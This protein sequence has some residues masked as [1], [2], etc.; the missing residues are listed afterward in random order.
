VSCR[1]EQI[2]LHY[3]PVDAALQQTVLDLG[4]LPD[5]FAV[6]LITFVVPTKH[7][8]FCVVFMINSIHKLTLYIPLK[9][10]GN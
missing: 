4:A 5:T 2:A 9:V 7:C 8:R 3:T 6:Q 1:L 10:I